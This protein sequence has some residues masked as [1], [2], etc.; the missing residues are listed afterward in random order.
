MPG[1]NP[2][3][4]P[5]GDRILSFDVNPSADGDYDRAIAAVLSTGVESVSLTLDWATLE[6]NLGQFD[7][8]L[9]D[10]ANGYYPSRGVRVSLSTSPV[11]TTSR[12]LPADIADR[13]LNDPAV[14]SRFKAMLDSLRV[15]MRDVQFSRIHI[16][17]EHDALFGTDAAAW[18]DWQEFWDAVRPHAKA[19]WPTVP[20]GTEFTSNGLLGAPASFTRASNRETDVVAVSYYPLDPGFVVRPVAT[21]RRDIDRLTS[22]YPGRAFHFTQAGYPSSATNGSSEALQRDFVIA[23]FEAW[24]AYATQI[25]LVNFTWLHDISAQALEDFQNLYGLHDPAF[26]AY[27]GSIGFRTYAGSGRDKLAWTEFAKQ[28]SARGWK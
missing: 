25:R 23:V 16:G 27:L 2:S 17:S 1:P 26:A 24:D 20:I 21:V 7:P 5:K 10:I 13:R 15:H 18:A 19:L 22:A 12:S 11:L 3:V 6:P 28:A 14:I 4:V 9:P 8:T